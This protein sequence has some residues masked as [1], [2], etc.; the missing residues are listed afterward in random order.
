L[1]GEQAHWARFGIY[2]HPGFLTATDSSR[3]CDAIA[4]LPSETA[5]VFP[6]VLDG[7]TVD[8]SIR[9]A[10]W[11]D[12]PLELVEDLSRRL[13]AVTSDLERWYG[14]GLGNREGLQFLSY[15]AG[16]FYRAHRDR[17]RIAGGPA[18]EARGRAVSVVIFLN[19]ASSP[20]P[21]EGGALTFYGLIDDERWKGVG[22]P[23][24]PRTGMLV[25]FRSETLH[26]VTTITRGVRRV[27]VTW[28]PLATETP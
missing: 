24:T 6:D 15:P 3:I 26:E 12:P 2:V 5:E 22:L 25:A 27:A 4:S 11:V 23:L 21:F 13:I 16:G 7:R 9:R 28:F 10:E 14:R 20:D 19:D 18:D 1:L 17:P 8:P